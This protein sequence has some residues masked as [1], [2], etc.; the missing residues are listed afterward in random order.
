MTFQELVGLVKKV[1]ITNI[2]KDRLK[3]IKYH[4]FDI[5]DTTMKFNERNNKLNKLIEL[6][7]FEYIVKVKSEIVNNREEIEIK[8]QEFVLE[9]YEGIIIRNTMSNYGLGIRSK[10]L[11]KKKDFITDEYEIVGHGDGNGKE[12][13]CVIWTCKTKE[14]RIFTVRPKG[15]HEERK[16]L[17]IDS[18]KYIGK[19]LIV[20]FQELSS[21][22]F[23]PR[24]P[25]GIG[26]RDYE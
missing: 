16:E 3:L 15:T 10:D 11:Q 9:G 14:D 20:K 19:K 2:D 23:I 5:V 4:V 22:D 8:H 12:K 21:T 26:I 25:V 24:F 18:N 1:K 7:N 13:G 6:G 17:F